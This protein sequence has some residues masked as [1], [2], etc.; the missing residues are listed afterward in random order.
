[1]T[2]IDQM[3]ECSECHTQ[4]RAGV[5][6]AAEAVFGPYDHRPASLEKELRDA[7]AGAARLATQGYSKSDTEIAIEAISARLD[8][9]LGDLVAAVRHA[10]WEAATT[11]CAACGTRVEREALHVV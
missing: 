8:V 9:D 4:I 2:T 7:I 3:V 5:S 6:A 11:P 1:M 10:D